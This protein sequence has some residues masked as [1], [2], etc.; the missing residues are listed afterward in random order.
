MAMRKF[1]GTLAI[2]VFGNAAMVAAVAP[3]ANLTHLSTIYLDTQFN[4]TSGY[5]DNPLSLAFDGETAYVGGFN[6]SGAD[7]TIGV[8]KVSGLF[9]TEPLFTPM[10]L[11]QFVSPTGRGLDSLAYEAGNDSLILHHDAGG[12]Q[13]GFISRRAAS[14]GAEVW[15]VANPQGAR[16]L[17]A[18]GIDPLGDNG[19]PGVGFLV[20]G[21]GRRRLLSMTDGST[22]YDG[23]DGG[24]I[25]GEKDDVTDFGTAWRGVSF[26]SAGNIVTAE[27]DYYGYGV[28]IGTNQWQSL[29]G[30][31]DR[32]SKSI[33]KNVGSNF[34]GQGVAIIEESGS[35]LL[36]VSGRNMTQFTD[37][38]GGVTD[39]SDTNVQIRNLDGSTTGLTQIELNGG[40]NGVGTPWRNDTKALTFG[41]DG[42]G[43][44]T[45]LVVDFIERRLDVYQTS[46]GIV[47]DVAAGVETQAEAGYPL[48]TTADSLTKTGL[49][50]LVLDADNT[51]T[52]PTT[53]S[54]GTLEVASD[55]GL[56]SSAVTVDSGATLAVAAGISMRSPA[57]IVDGGTLSASS[58]TVDTAAGIASLAVNAGSLAGSPAVTVAGGG[59]FALPQDARVSVAVGSLAVAEGQGGGRIDLGAGQVAIEPGGITPAD[60]RADIIAGRAGGAWDGGAGI[61]SSAAAASAGGRAVGYVVAGDGGVTVSFAAPGD[62]D[63]NGLVNVFDLVA[64]DASG[65]YGTGAVAVWSDGDFNYDGVT[66]VFDLIGVDTAG[67]YGTGDYFPA[68]PTVAAGTAVAVPEPEAV[69]LL[70]VAVAAAWRMNRRR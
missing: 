70:A 16:P 15:S 7:A 49:G 14:D 31:N 56:G 63:L 17:G 52:G 51:F 53:V 28:R 42:G 45:L 4:E 3:A 9:G 61:T 66:N 6:N 48:I 57:V 33:V 41:V 30:T 25:L 5:G 65:T 24:I 67:A 60:I 62:T 18:V 50:T 68:G 8:V 59:E 2:L 27:Q 29:D 13:E 64:V 20:Q 47:I 12:S 26:D 39:V 10:P 23:S 11:T 1:L 69:G 55:G 36:A 21:S 54:A 35:S 44:G 37:L 34:V 58:L 43:R 22:I 40:E 38:L 46:S 19:S 32:T